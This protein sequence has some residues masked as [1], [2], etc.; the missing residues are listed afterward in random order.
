[1]RRAAGG[2]ERPIP[3]AAQ[4]RPAEETG[5]TWVASPGFSDPMGLSE[6]SWNLDEAGADPLGLCGGTAPDMFSTTSEMLASLPQ[7]IIGAYAQLGI[8]IERCS[9]LGAALSESREVMSR[10]SLGGS[11]H[12]RS[13]ETTARQRASRTAV[14][15]GAVGPLRSDPLGP[16]YGHLYA[17]T[18]DG[19]VMGENTLDLAGRCVKTYVDLVLGALSGV[20]VGLDMITIEI[21]EIPEGALPDEIVIRDPWR[22]GCWHINVGV[23]T[24]AAGCLKYACEQEAEKHARGLELVKEDLKQTWT[25]PFK[26]ARPRDPSMP[27]ITLP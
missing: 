4:R 15:V 22:G 27:C 21:A 17:A 13:G 10:L 25:K 23:I 16:G 11:T 19:R 14:T 3:V 6:Y 24:T 1:V 8:D 7:E 2:T 26:Q 12:E 9:V 5:K 20:I 18:P